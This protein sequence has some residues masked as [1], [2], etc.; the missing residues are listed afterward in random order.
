MKSGTTLLVSGAH[1]AAAGV[2]LAIAIGL[3]HAKLPQAP[4]DDAARAKAEEAKA[5]A[6][7]AAQ[8]EGEQL[9]KAQDRVA[10]YY[11]K[12]K[13]IKPAAAAIPAAAAPKK[14]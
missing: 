14:K 6:A 10:D 5:K 12:S 11:R 8:K 13:G 9:A 2:G 7:E 1:A 4:M 3:S